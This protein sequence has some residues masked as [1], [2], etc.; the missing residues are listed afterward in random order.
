MKKNIKKQCKTHGLTDFILEGR[1]YYRC[2]KC[3]SASVT[4][5]RTKMKIKAV[6]YKGGKC[7]RCGYDRSIAALEFHHK[8]PTQKDFEIS[9]TGCTR[10]WEKIKAEVNKCE[11]LCANC[12]REIHN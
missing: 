8:D 12:H 6:Q 7:E 11:L 10:S 3:R 2:K 9:T 4:K 5:Y 1:G